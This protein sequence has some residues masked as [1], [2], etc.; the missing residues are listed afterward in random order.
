MP[1]TFDPRMSDAQYSKALSFGQFKTCMWEIFERKPYSGRD[2][3]KFNE[4]GI[5]TGIFGV[6]SIVIFYLFTKRPN[7]QYY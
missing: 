3:P 6:T 7:K 1:S 2:K 5:A 4:P